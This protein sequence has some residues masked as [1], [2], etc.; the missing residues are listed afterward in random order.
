MSDRDGH[1]R[2][3]RPRHQRRQRRRRRRLFGAF[4]L[5]SPGLW[6]VVGDAARR[7]AHLMT[8]DRLHQKAYAATVFASAVFWAA[9]LYAA[10][11]RRG[12]L[13]Q[14][15]AGLFLAGF[16]LS[17]GVQAAFR[18]TTATLSPLMMCCSAPSAPKL[19]GPTLRPVWPV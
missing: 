4:V 13:R 8:F 15:A 14:V 1:E 2:L 7:W 11:R 19:K 18:S 16:T 12:F 10:S 17:L 5:L 6:V 9:L 3:L